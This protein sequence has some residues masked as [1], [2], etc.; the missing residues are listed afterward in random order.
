MD[1]HPFDPSLP[2]LE[3][4]KA[5]TGADHAA[6]FPFQK[7][8]VCFKMYARAGFGICMYVDNEGI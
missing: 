4:P 5:L 1:G 2:Y 8:A 7:L 3:R 6:Q